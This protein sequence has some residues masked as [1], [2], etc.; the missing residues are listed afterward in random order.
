MSI[1]LPDRTK[2]KYYYNDGAYDK[3]CSPESEKVFEKTQCGIL[4]SYPRAP[5]RD[6][7]SQ[8]RNILRL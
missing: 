2:G 6:V 4:C 8:S 5:D 7:Q 3:I 1:M